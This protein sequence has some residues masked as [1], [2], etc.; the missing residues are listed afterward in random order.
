MFIV[1]LLFT[2]IFLYVVVTTFYLVI[3]TVAAY[4]FR[5]KQGLAPEPLSIVVV[6]PAHN[7]ALEIEKT[8]SNVKPAVILKNLVPLW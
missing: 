5:K 3:L 4:F 1:H 7:E 8:I 6:I 2:L